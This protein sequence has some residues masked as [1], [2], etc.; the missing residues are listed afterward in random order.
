MLGAIDEFRGNKRFIVEGQLGE[1]GM[2]VVH[3][4]RDVDRGEVV[5]LKTMT[6]LDP[7][8]L[9]RFKREF[10][11]LADITHDNVVQLYELFSESDQ[12]FYT[13]ELVDGCDLITWVHSSLSMPPPPLEVL[14]ARESMGLETSLRHAS[15]VQETLLAPT[16]LYA[17]L[18]TSS[19]IPVGAP[20]ATPLPHARGR[21]CVRDV[22]RLRSALRQLASG[23]AAIHAHGKL[24]RDLKPSN[25]M[26]ARSGRVVILDFGVVGEYRRED[27]SVR[28]D[29]ILVGTPAYMSPEQAAFNPAT[30]ASDWYAVG[31]ILFEAL[32]ARMPFEGSTTELLLAKQHPLAARPHDLVE[33]IPHDLEQLCVDLLQR[34]P[35]ARPTADEIIRRLEGDTPPTVSASVEVPFVGRRLQ[36]NQL[37]AAFEASREGTPVIAMLHGRSG[38][39]KSALAARFLSQIEARPDALVLSGRC[40]DREAVPFKAVDQVVDELS[41][42]LGQL[43][44]DDAFGLL[45]DGVR[46]L[47]RLFPVIA[48][49]RVVAESPDRDGGV[50]DP[51]EMR[52]RAFTALRELLGA[53]AQRWSLVIHIDDLQ[54]GDA[55]SVQ[56]LEALLSPPAPRP[57]LLVCGY[58]SEAAASSEALVALR[59][60]WA[61]LGAACRVV[62][63]EVGQ[64]T[65][66]EAM[67]L[68]RTMVDSVDPAL[69]EAI[70]AE[71]QGNP[72]FVAELGRWANEGGK[73]AR[74]DRSIA[75]D[76]MVL[77]RVNELT[78]DARRLLEIL[79]V[80]GKP[81]RHVIAE[82]AAGTEGRRRSA[83]MALRAARLLSMRGLADRDLV[84]TSHDRIRQTVV[85]SLDDQARRERHLAL[86]RAFA[87]HEHPDLEAAFEHFRAAG[88][89]AAARDYALRA[90]HA[91][92]RALAFLRAA[93]LYRAAIDLG[94]PSPELL[95][96]RLG[97]AL[98]NAGRGAE[99]AEAYLQAASLSHGAPAT[100]LRRMAADHL[101]KSG[102]ELRG[103]ETLRRVLEDVGLRYPESPQAA[104][105]SILWHEARLRLSSLNPPVRRAAQSQRDP[106]LLA[107]FDAAFTAAAGLTTVDLLRSAD[108]AG[109]AL[110]LALEAGEPV[111]LGRALAVAAGNVAARGEPSRRRADELVRASQR[112]AAQADDPHA[113]ALA[114]LAAG[115]VHFFLGE[116]RGARASL[117][118]AESVLRAQCRAVAWELANTQVWTCNALIL[119]GELREATRR[120]PGLVDEARARDD[121]FALMHMAYP[122]CVTH[123]VADDVDAAWR[124]TELAAAHAGGAFTAFHWGAFISAASVERYKG[125]V[126][127]AW[128]RAQSIAQPLESSSLFRVAL[129]R[130]FSAYERG[131][132]AIAAAAAGVDRTAALQAAEKCARRLVRDNIGF[133]PAMGHLLLAGA[134]SV[135]GDRQRALQ[136][137]ELALPLLDA[138]DLGYLAACARYR[139]GQLLGGDAGRE[140]VQRSERFFEAQGVVSPER[141]LAMSAPG[142]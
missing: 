90:A 66:S 60:T 101:L 84:E 28:V 40:Y 7:A 34:D 75:L 11:A 16:E 56:L 50:I 103:L 23:V 94:A 64:L 137:L 63:V 113:R 65:D 128:A 105:A 97:Q 106:R 86:A 53:I 125:D 88:D 124:V 126:R 102:R 30:P 15:G 68:A 121:S 48:N 110:R 24:H 136:A 62:E 100:E 71:A 91:A 118:D 20:R 14:E 52:R 38:M 111:R 123:I 57:L 25:V 82:R 51:M 141:C 87:G 10:R 44:D 41:R 6:R 131:L 35:R 115:I 92:D 8:A 112:A 129:I 109:R 4:A 95:Y 83:A 13:M 54:W 39:G 74:G 42:W 142:F 22:P 127:G 33:G 61:T 69:P 47:A 72:L 76:G 37:Q 67:D 32:T 89:D 77:A 93:S 130:A 114:L 58:R 21:F 46:A 133:A 19:P 27:R 81:L 17:R 78:E 140:L 116:W 3:R 9:L 108:F 59:S 134:H 120:I 104:V 99:A 49:A 80:A 139:R 45:P 117:E 5:A 12:W 26:V 122:V 79:S 73:V 98:A 85:A 135:R 119:S 2:G 70:A 18:L 43:S 31:V 132:S 138:A 36:L 1:G 29:E 96:A 55:D 107:R